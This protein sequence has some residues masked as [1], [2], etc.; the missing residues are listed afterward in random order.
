MNFSKHPWDFN[1]KHFLCF[2]LICC[3]FWESFLFRLLRQLHS[4]I[5]LWTRNSFLSR[6]QNSWWHTFL[7]KYATQG[8]LKSLLPPAPVANAFL[9]KLINMESQDL[10]PHRC[11]LMPHKLTS[12]CFPLTQ[13]RWFSGTFLS[14]IVNFIFSRLVAGRDYWGLLLHR[15]QRWAPLNRW[16]EH[17]YLICFNPAEILT[18]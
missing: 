14:Q 2:R 7:R 15:I 4:A 8:S 9:V 13:R 10:S 5:M 11:F 6:N 3:L 17:K 1:W 18:G 16:W 12:R